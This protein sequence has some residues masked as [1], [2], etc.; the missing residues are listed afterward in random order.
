MEL[1]EDVMTDSGSNHS[2]SESAPPLPSDTSGLDDVDLDGLPG[3]EHYELATNFHALQEA[4]ADG[5]VTM[6]RQFLTEVFSPPRVTM[7]ATAQGFT[8]EYCFDITYNGWDALK[9]HMQEQL[10]KVLMEMK[11]GCLVLSPPCT[12]FSALM[13]PR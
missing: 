3:A 5:S 8:S 1:P 12:M 4:V 7:A 11:P 10:L 9:P 6:N 2:M 13:R